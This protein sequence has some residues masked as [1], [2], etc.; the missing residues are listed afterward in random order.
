MSIHMQLQKN[1]FFTTQT[2]EVRTLRVLQG[3]LFVLGCMYAWAL[4]GTV[5]TT[6]ERKALVRENEHITSHVAE[7]ES[8]YL[9]ASKQINQ[10]KALALG[11][12]ASKDIL[13]ATKGIDS[14][15]AFNQ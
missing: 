15:V 5:F 6:A 12:S 11:L 13:Y 9:D 7:L 4:I 3:A 8:A 14:A 2:F 1:S 10:D